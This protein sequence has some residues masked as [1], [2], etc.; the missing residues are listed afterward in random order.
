M[1]I[2]L[3]NIFKH[4]SQKEILDRLNNLKSDSVG[5][6]GVMNA[7]QMLHHLT[8][9]N[10]IVL[11][12]ITLPDKS[13]F[14]SRTF[15]WWMTYL[16]MRPSVTRLKKKSLRTYKEVDIVRNKI[17]VQDFETE[18]QLFIQ[19]LNQVIASNKFPKQHPLFGSIKKSGWGRW[20]YV[21]CDYHLVQFGV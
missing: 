3:K 1:A 16:N 2:I 13:R 17:S 21:H 18:K 19:K 14:L 15:F 7:S 5:L 10:Q 12:E 9:A 8:M 11:G 6:W 20:V 4:E